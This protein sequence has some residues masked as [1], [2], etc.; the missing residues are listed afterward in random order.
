MSRPW[1]RRKDGSFSSET[2]YST[3]SALRGGRGSGG[4]MKV[5]SGAEK[6]SYA[7]LTVWFLFYEGWVIKSF[8]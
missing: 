7:G 6:E 3:R 5:K 1:G 2:D 8:R 4:V